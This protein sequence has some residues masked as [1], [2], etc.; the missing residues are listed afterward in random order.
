M[1][2]AKALQYVSED[3][4]FKSLVRSVSDALEGSAPT[5]TLHN[6]LIGVRISAG[7]SQQQA[8]G[9]AELQRLLPYIFAPRR[10]AFVRDK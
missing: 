5:R 6:G 3:T 1:S 10:A 8:V 4:T 9:R 2:Q 7:F